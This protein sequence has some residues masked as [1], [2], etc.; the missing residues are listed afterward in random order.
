VPVSGRWFTKLSVVFP[1]ESYENA[2]KM[3]LNHLHCICFQIMPQKC[4]VSMP[5]STQYIKFDLRILR[6]AVRKQRCAEF[7]YKNFLSF[8]FF[9]INYWS[10]CW[11][12]NKNSCVADTTLPVNSVSSLPTVLQTSNAMDWSPCETLGRSADREMARLLW[13]LKVHYR[14]KLF[15]S[16][17]SPQPVKPS[18]RPHILFL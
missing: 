1:K 12:D 10:W 15:A 6:G 7:S 16:T 2:C 4:T 3:H 18:P 8:V 5:F 14:V 13:N 17:Y 11:V 9:G